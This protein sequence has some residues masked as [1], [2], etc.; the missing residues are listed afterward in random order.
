MYETQ[1]EA[2]YG[3]ASAVPISR[4]AEQRLRA[5]RIEELVKGAG[6]RLGPTMTTRQVDP[7]HEAAKGGPPSDEA[8]S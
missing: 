5:P 2:V 8:A 4:T 7:R 1:A 6:F 3:W